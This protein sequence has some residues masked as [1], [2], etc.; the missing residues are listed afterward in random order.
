MAPLASRS[1]TSCAKACRSCMR[2]SS[3][4]LPS[5]FSQSSFLPCRACLD[6][7]AS[8]SFLAG[9]AM[10]EKYLEGQAAIVTGGMRGIGLGIARRLHERGAKVAIWDRDTPAWDKAA[11]GFAPELVVKADVSDVRSV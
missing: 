3:P 2:C 8:E 10:T 6:T 4:C 11:K 1:R 5:W 7:K 9:A